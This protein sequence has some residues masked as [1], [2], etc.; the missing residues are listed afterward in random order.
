MAR[1]SDAI[2]ETLPYF[3]YRGMSKGMPLLLLAVGYWLLAM[4]TAKSQK[5]IAN[6]Q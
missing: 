3:I 2:I 5:R 4:L 6:S 1:K